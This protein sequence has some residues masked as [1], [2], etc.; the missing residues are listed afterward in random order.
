VKCHVATKRGQQ[1]CRKPGVSTGE[2]RTGNIPSIDDDASPREEILKCHEIAYQLAAGCP[3]LTRLSIKN[4]SD[5]YH[6]NVLR[7]HARRPAAWA[8][9]EGGFW[10]REE[11]MRLAMD[12]YRQK[13]VRRLSFNGRRKQQLLAVQSDSNDKNRVVALLTEFKEDVGILFEALKSFPVLF[14]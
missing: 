10:A 7:G 6:H 13:T 8:N 3:L 12:D 1:P 11:V 9:D 5:V 14:Q 4:Y 2:S